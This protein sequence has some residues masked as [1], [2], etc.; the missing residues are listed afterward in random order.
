MTKANIPP[1]K[2]RIGL[3]LVPEELKNSPAPH[4]RRVQYL[5]TIYELLE[6]G[7]STNAHVM[8]VRLESKVARE[9]STVTY[10]MEIR[11]LAKAIRQGE[12]KDGAEAERERQ[13]KQKTQQMYDEQLKMLALPLE[14]LKKHYLTEIP[15]KAT[16]PNS[17]QTCERC[18][19]K[20]SIDARKE[21][22]KFH[23]L[24]RPYN[25]AIG[26]RDPFFPCCNEK[27]DESSGCQEAPSHVYKLLE[28][29]ELHYTRNF[30]Y[31]PRNPQAMFAVGIDCEMVYTSLGLE[32]ARITAVDWHTSKVVYDRL[33]YPA[34]EIWDLNTRFSGISDIHSGT[35]V[36][37]HHRPTLSYKEAMEL[38][39]QIVGESTFLIG[40][41]LENDLI[42]MRWVH[43]NIVDTAAL[44]PPIRKRTFALKELAFKYLSREIQKG[45]HDSMEDSLA[46]MDVVKANILSEMRKKPT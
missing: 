20:F 3:P 46:A 25:A 44:Y 4:P 5:Q 1:K 17:V 15:Q 37:G 38:L 9:S 42:A 18:S 28:P 39:F 19:E 35:I 45:E 21:R 32:L 24:R 14:K 23:L 22:C 6:K 30:S 13:N 2:R 36:Y 33:I 12:Y 27:L 41:G 11:K 8:A 16:V 10:P 31:T 29:E 43:R 7:G 26:K 34:G 40:H